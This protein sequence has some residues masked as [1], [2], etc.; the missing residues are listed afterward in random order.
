MHA[1]GDEVKELPMV[2]QARAQLIETRL[3]ALLSRIK[4]APYL[5]LCS[6]SPPSPALVAVS[7]TKPLS[8]IL[9]ACT[10]GHR[11]FGENYVAEL[12]QK[13]IQLAQEHPDLS[14]EVRWHYIGALQGNKLRTLARIPGLACIQTLDSVLHA[15]KLDQYRAEILTETVSPFGHDSK[16]SFPLLEVL[17]QVNTSGESQK[18]G[19]SPGAE[20]DA[21]VDV[22]LSRCPHLHFCGLMTIGSATGDPKLDFQT[23]RNEAERLLVSRPD[24]RIPGGFQLSMGMSADFETAISLGATIVRIGSVLFD[25]RHG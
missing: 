17:V 25:P 4:G 11:L 8:D 10:A 14:K 3:L 9:A 19:L 20:V 1:G 23:L 24:I 7:K 18:H 5:P 6:D 2:M 12:T 16:A 15:I 21:L 22:L 13:A